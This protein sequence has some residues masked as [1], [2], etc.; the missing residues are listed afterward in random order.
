MALP[1]ANA[2]NKAV[3][4][5]SSDEIKL[6]VAFKSLLTKLALPAWLDPSQSEFMSP[7]T[8][9]MSCTTWN[10][11]RWFSNPKGGNLCL[12]EGSKNRVQQAGEGNININEGDRNCT[13][14]HGI[15]NQIYLLHNQP[16]A[17]G[18]SGLTQ[19]SASDN[20]AYQ[21][22][23]ENKSTTRGDG[24]LMGQQGDDHDSKVK[25]DRNI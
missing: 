19:V 10:Q 21:N 24:S 3:D 22:G 4:D 5:S 18:S 25:G 11:N 17:Q 20:L 13:A 12:I 7:V 16:Q 9:F 23:K 1:V 2:T 8:L 6:R 15:A 14:Q